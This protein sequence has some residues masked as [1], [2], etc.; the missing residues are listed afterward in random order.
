MENVSKA[1]ML[2]FSTL[3]F[4]AAL[5]IT[6]MLYDEVDDFMEQIVQRNYYRHVMAGE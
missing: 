5:V 6:A 1:L 2:G 3:I 4:A